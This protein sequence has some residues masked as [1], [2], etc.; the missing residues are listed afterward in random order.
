MASFGATATRS[1]VTAVT[2][3]VR[4][5]PSSRAR[6]PRTA[7]GPS[8]ASGVAVDVDA[9]DAVEHEVELVARALLVG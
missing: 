4:T 2:V 9:G 3:E 1:G 7:P 6:S 5:P 8:S